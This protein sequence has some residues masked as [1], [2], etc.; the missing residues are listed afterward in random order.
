MQQFMLSLIFA[1]AI[2][3]GCSSSDVESNRPSPAESPTS[4]ATSPVENEHDVIGIWSLDDDEGAVSG[5]NTDCKG[6]GFASDFR[7]GTSVKV[8]NANGTVIGSGTTTNFASEEELIETFNEVAEKS[9]YKRTVD[10]E[11]LQSIEGQYCILWF[12]MKLPTTDFYVVDM[13]GS[14]DEL[15]YS[16][17]EMQQN[18]WT[19]T[20]S[21]NRSE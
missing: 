21:L 6:T 8:T 12:E 5:S 15:T 1:G 19:L 16:L 2:F 10:H 14:G 18:N 4:E 17:D 11:Y 7:A 13:P 9:V 3:A 20:V